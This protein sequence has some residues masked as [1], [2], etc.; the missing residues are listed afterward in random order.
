MEDLPT[1]G[2]NVRTWKQSIEDK[3]DRRYDSA[4]GRKSEKIYRPG[5]KRMEDKENRRCESVLRKESPV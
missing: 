1:Y 3:D 5:N 2:R 4:E